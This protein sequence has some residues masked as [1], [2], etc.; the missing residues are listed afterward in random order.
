M[1]HV[2]IRKDK[3]KCF[4]S[5]LWKY[6]KKTF[7][8]IF[9]KCSIFTQGNIIP[10]TTELLKRELNTKNI[11]CDWAQFYEINQTVVDQYNSA[12][13]QLTRSQLHGLITIEQIWRDLGYRK[14]DREKYGDLFIH[15]IPIK[16]LQYI[17]EDAN[18]LISKVNKSFEM[19]LNNESID[20]I[21]EMIERVD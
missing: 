9:N 6:S 15:I 2:T 17:S 3:R 16:S 7:N 14:I 11:E 18:R 5:F 19:V 1:K 10:I 8:F 13:K 20:K 21:I 12:R 4:E